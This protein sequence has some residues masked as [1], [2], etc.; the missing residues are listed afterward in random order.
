[1]PWWPV[2][3]LMAR[4]NIPI[5]KP[6]ISERTKTRVMDILGSGFIASGDEVR[7][8]EQAFAGYTGAAEG[9]A[10]SSGTTAL[11]VAL[12]A[13][14]I[15]PGDEVITTPFTFIATSN[16]VLYCGARVVFADVDPATYNLDPEAIRKAAREHPKAKA[17]LAVHLFGLPCDMD[18]VIGV[19]A[20]YGLIV[21]E[22]CA[23]AH[24][25]L[26]KG[27]M[28][29]SIGLLSAFSFY[30]TKNMTCGE[31]GMVVTSDNELA[32]RC[33]LLVNHGSAIRYQHEILGYNYRLTNI[34]AVI[35]STQL[36]D[37]DDFIAARSA[38]ASRL[39]QGLSGLFGIIT[40]WVPDGCRHAFNQYTIK[41]PQGRDDLLK[42]LEREGIGYGLFYPQPSYKQALYKELGYGDCYCP[43][44]EDL[45]AQV[46]SL[47]VHPLLDE[48][49]IDRIIEVIGDWAPNKG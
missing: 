18:A 12:L 4:C 30:P 40:P 15:G 7:K 8:F 17:V 41:V 22:D 38:N 13:A 21:I 14:G 23:Q 16:A 2:E 42:H 9:I 43:V 31:G 36:E 26:Y 49:E 1:M 24:G 25:A 11:H 34:A 29:G 3:I 6:N 39:T 44:A 10:T 47:P 37:L 32:E 5:A 45:S 46:V 33:R 48:W 35:G 20:E 28:V 19:A 27:R